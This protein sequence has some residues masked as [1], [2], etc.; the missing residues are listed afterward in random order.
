MLT[1]L[2]V[3]AAI[4]AGALAVAGVQFVH[5]LLLAAARPAAPDPVDAAYNSL[6]AGRRELRIDTRTGSHDELPIRPDIR[7]TLTAYCEGMWQHTQEQP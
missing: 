6:P 1:A 5:G 7:A 3:L 2:A 4:A